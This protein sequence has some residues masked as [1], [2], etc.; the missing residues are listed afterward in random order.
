MRKSDALENV[1]VPLRL[2]ENVRL[3]RR[4]GFAV[5]EPFSSGTDLPRSSA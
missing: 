3:V 5:V 4:S 2:D 1:L